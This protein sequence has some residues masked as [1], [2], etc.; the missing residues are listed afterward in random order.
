M[1]L[2]CLTAFSVISMVP[3]ISEF[4]TWPNPLFFQYLWCG[5][6]VFFSRDKE[7]EI[8]FKWISCSMKICNK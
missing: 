1:Q 4:S 2:L 5:V 6:Y 8:D 7:I 3:V